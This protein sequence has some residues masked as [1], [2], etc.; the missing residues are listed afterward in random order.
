MKYK[1]NECHDEV[2]IYAVEVPTTDHKLKEV[3]EAKE[4]EIENLFHYDLFEETEDI[5]Q[6]KIGSH[7][8]TRPHTL[9]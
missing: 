6:E 8:V 5:G 2:A 9:L 3:V 7:W 1:N 4:K